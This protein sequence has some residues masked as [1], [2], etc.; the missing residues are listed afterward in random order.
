MPPP[1]SDAIAIS[2]FGEPPAPCRE[3][4]L[5]DGRRWRV[6]EEIPVA[7]VIG[8]GNYAVMLATPADLADFAVGFV[9]SERLARSSD[10][11]REVRIEYKDGGAEAHIRLGAEAMERFDLTRRRR[12][13]AGRAGCGLCGLESAETIFQALPRVAADIAPAPEAL[14]RALDELPEHQPL[15]RRTR[16]VHAAA[17]AGLDGRIERVREDVGR[18]NA[19]D[20]LI[21]ANIRAGVDPA[22]GFVLMSS[23]CSY[24]LIEKSARAGYGAL[25][26]LSG[27]TAFAIRKAREA[28]IR[29]YARSGGVLLPVGD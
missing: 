16:S 27:P 9:I 1:P 15:N 8:G 5:A 3:Q 21:G 14:A 17:W 4:A 26:V 23:R 13:I 12:N 19:L 25:A 20:K 22:D 2:E 6:A 10:E 18:H 7:V 29:L 24:E 28:G 11:I